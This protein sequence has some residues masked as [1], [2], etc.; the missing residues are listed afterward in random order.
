MESMED[1]LLTAIWLAVKE[2]MGA[3]PRVE[4]QRA[5]RQRLRKDFM[6]VLLT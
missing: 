6:V 5:R 3:N 2:D 4:P 1:P